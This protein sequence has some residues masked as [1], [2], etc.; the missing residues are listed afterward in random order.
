MMQIEDVGGIKK[1]HWAE[2][3]D[4][5]KSG[6]LAFRMLPKTNDALRR[7]AH[8][9]GVSPGSV[10]NALVRDLLRDGPVPGSVTERH[11]GMDARDSAR[12]ED[13]SQRRTAS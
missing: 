10:C 11:L 6:S 3:E 8:E 13:P 4:R 12:V 2:Y 9:R 1:K 5:K 7:L